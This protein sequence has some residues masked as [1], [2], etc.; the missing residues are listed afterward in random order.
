MCLNPITIRNNTKNYHPEITPYWVKVPCGTCSECIS[1]YR[2]N[3]QSRMQAEIQDTYRLGGKAFI[4]LLTYRENRIPTFELRDYDIPGSEPVKLY[5][6]SHE[7]IKAFRR[8]LID[9]IHDFYFVPYGK[10]SYMC[11]CEYGESPN[12]THRSHYHFLFCIKHPSDVG[13][14]DI[15]Y[16]CNRLWHIADSNRAGSPE[17]VGP[18]HG[19]ANPYRRVNGVTEVPLLEVQS[20]YSGSKYLS[21]YLSKSMDFYQ[22]PILQKFMD[23]L[24][25]LRYDC[26]RHL[27]EF[28]LDVNDFNDALKQ[29]R[30]GVQVAKIFHP[31]P[32]LRQPIVSLHPCFAQYFTRYAKLQRIK[33]FFPK[34]WQSNGFGA[35]FLNVLE[36]QSPSEVAETL[37][38]GYQT[39]DSRG[40]GVVIP[41]SS[42]LRNKFFYTSVKRSD[43]SIVRALRHDKI[44]H[45]VEYSRWNFFNSFE[46]YRSYLDSHYVEQLVKKINNEKVD[47]LYLRYQEYSYLERDIFPIILYGQFYS[48][49]YYNYK[50]VS[51][52]DAHFDNLIDVYVKSKDVE[53]ITDVPFAS[54]DYYIDRM[55]LV[56]Y[57]ILSSQKWPEL[58]VASEFFS[59]LTAYRYE[60]E[61]QKQNDKDNA[62]R[63]LYS[64]IC[65]NT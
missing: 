8:D 19:L 47:S 48:G 30:Q 15:R 17:K 5:G 45:Y 55:H 50:M 57:E 16:I 36:S 25:H 62:I 60:F 28:R 53:T 2:R 27:D 13:E 43:G 29:I 54:D 65:T 10:F 64:Y 63:R 7:H 61:R 33:R 41:F 40:N 18:N 56:P 4:L 20:P 42:Y 26:L 58:H 1:G 49:R 11:A 46:L 32:E 59:A 22:Q 6:F 35:S 3:W 39:I 44:S 12:G 37:S 34:H 52:Y 14:S 9:Y 23:S 51:P 21:K 38:L 24:K 31:S